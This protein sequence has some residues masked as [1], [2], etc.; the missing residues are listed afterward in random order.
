METIRTPEERK[1]ELKEAQ[2]TK[3]EAERTKVSGN[4]WFNCFTSGLT[5]VM[6]HTGF[7]NK[8]KQLLEKLA[9]LNEKIVRLGAE[10]NYQEP[11]NPIK[12]ELLNELAQLYYEF[13]EL[14]A[15]QANQQ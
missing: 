13:E 11:P 1:A 7:L 15:E 12:E 10:T 2:R 9:R 3:I 14:R 4:N 6:A 8:G 5:I